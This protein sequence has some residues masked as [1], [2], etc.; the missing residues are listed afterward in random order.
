VAL[1]ALVLY[2]LWF[3]VALGVR[4]LVALR[5]TGDWGFRGVSGAPVW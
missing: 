4:T 3:A 5:R 1:A 2:L